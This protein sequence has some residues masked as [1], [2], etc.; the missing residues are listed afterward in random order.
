MDKRKMKITALGFMGVLVTGAFLLGSVTGAG[1]ETMKCRTAET[2]TKTEMLPVGD[3]E[4][5]VLVLQMV[6]GL[7]FMENGE[8]A[9]MKA[10]VTADG[11]PG[12]PIQVNGYSITTFEDGS[13]IVGKVQRLMTP[14]KSGIFPATMTGEIVKGTGRFEG[15]KGTSTS[16]GKNFMPGKGE[17]MTISDDVTI[18]YTLPPK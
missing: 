16:T 4:G 1:A 17:A 2:V 10:Y 9:K 12:K 11:A 15:I 18:T 3:E 5:H 6:E 14:D 8:I 13:T 7:V